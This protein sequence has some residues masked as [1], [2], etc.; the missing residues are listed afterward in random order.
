VRLVDVR[1]TVVAARVV[2][3]LCVVPLEPLSRPDRMSRT[4]IVTPRR[5]AAGAR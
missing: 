2:T 4:A 1:A 5:K 3:G